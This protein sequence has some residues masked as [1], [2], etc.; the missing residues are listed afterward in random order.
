MGNKIGKFL[1]AILLLSQSLSMVAADIENDKGGVLSGVVL[2][3]RS[4]QPVEYATIA[5]YKAGENVVVTG[6]VTNPQGEFKI[7]G[8]PMGQFW[9]E[10]SFLGYK[11]QKF[12]NIEITDAKKTFQLGKVM[13]EPSAENLNEVQVVGERKS[14]EYRID[15]KVVNVGNQSTTA[16]M[17]AVEVLEN[18]PSIKVDIEGNV[19]LRGSGG[20]TV[21][22]D[23]KPSILEGSDALR[24]IPASSIDNIEI[25]TN[26][27]AKYQPDGTAG[28]INV[29]TKKNKSQGVNGQASVSA[30]MY[31]NYGG[32]VLLNMRKN[33]I[34]YSLG[35]DYN[36][37]KFPGE[38]KSLRETYQ[39]NPIDTVRLSASGDSRREM[40]MW[41][42]KGGIEV[43][44]NDKNSFTL[45]GRFGERSMTFTNDLIFDETTQVAGYNNRYKSLELSDR[46]GVFYSVNGSW[47]HNFSDKGHNITTLFD[48]GSRSSD[49]KSVSE[50][51]DLNNNPTKGKRS[52]ESGPGQRSELRID[53]VLPIN[54]LSKFEAG[55]Q[56]RRNKE[57]DETSMDTL[58]I[59]SGNYITD[60]LY[61]KNTDGLQDVYALYTT[62]SSAWKQ[63]GYQ[64]GLRGEY[65]NRLIEYSGD[66][67]TIDRMDYFPTLH[68]SYKLPA[69]NQLMASYARRV[70]RTRGWYLEPFITW[71]DAYN[72]RTGN[73]DILPEFIDSY[74]LGYLKQFKNAYFSLEGFYRITHNKVETLATVWDDVDNPSGT[75][76][77]NKPYNI[78]EDYSLGLEGTLN[79]KVKKW[80]DAT[81][82]GS[83]SDYEVTGQ[84]E[85]KDFSNKSFNWST[86]L[87]NTFYPYKN[88]QLQLNGNHN[89]ATATAQ[90]QNE[91][92]YSVDAA[93]RLEWLNRKLST[94]IQAR[95]IFAT[96]VRESWRRGDTF[97]NYNYSRN[98][99]PF[100][101][102]TATYRFNNYNPKRQN[103]RT[104]MGAD[105]GGGDDF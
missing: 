104:S 100:I 3:S 52:F 13:L 88:T 56:G 93:L 103:G 16:S 47:M 79:F 31:G 20:F 74:E 5:V 66:D 77:L 69:E 38:S 22:I 97:Y 6:T 8:L 19:S 46:G 73:P 45:S 87:N 39:T 17:T 102:V 33:K 80:W 35:A 30:G 1:A 91:G 2:D 27:S 58:D 29:I 81:L 64:V 60:N 86:R 25:I 40:Q 37:R 11:N 36:N 23:G 63:F 21:L 9:A 84:A 92:Y 54:E 43:N 78:G 67:F 48:I 15:K 12:E 85:G 95:D 14:F 89:S 7:T 90:G 42:I 76:L 65:T 82:M 75:I 71:Q 105:D 101:T 53:Y 41:G 28:I 59:A 72:V 18:V 55:F 10:I 98:L 32:D 51:T 24:Q 96:A 57:G 44:L 50:L 94:V 26:P 68:L 4:K 61:N 49:E 34:N 83:L 70:E 99:S 62:Y